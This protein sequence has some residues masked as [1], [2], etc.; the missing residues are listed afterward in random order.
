MAKIL[1]PT[2]LRQFTE[3]KDAV[4]VSGA[5]VGEALTSLTTRSCWAV[6]P[7]GSPESD[8]GW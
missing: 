5:T 1:I 7:T 3:Q 2:A 6:R 4:D 8:W